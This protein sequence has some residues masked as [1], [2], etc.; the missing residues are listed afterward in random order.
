MVRTYPFCIALEI[1][2][3]P[4]TLADLVA[5]R[6][7]FLD[8]TL[9]GIIKRFEDE[10][11]DTR[12]SIDSGIGMSS[13]M[14]LGSSISSGDA[15]LYRP[16][17]NSD[18]GDAEGEEEADLSLKSSSLTRSDSV[19]ST[20]SKKLA[21]EEAKILRAGHK[22]R[23]GILKP[24][25]WLLLS[26]VEEIAAN[27]NHIRMLHELLDD[28]DNEDLKREA[29]ERGVV[30]VFEEHREELLQKLKEDDPEY[31]E[32][33]V[34]SQVLARANANLPVADPKHAATACESA[35]EDGPRSAMN[36]SAIED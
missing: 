15:E 14:T 18:D 22:F 3:H 1:C 21:N 2:V 31:W 30:P 6:L 27:P 19:L 7:L 5:A 25:H 10:F 24:E 26:G 8:N 13:S 9:K 23:V 33:F 16:N 35:V 34:E 20:T 17:T 11:P 36:E 29:E 4:G 32:R 28:L 12:E